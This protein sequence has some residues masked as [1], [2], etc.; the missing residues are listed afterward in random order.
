MYRYIFKSLVCCPWCSCGLPGDGLWF[1]GSYC[2]DES[3]KTRVVICQENVCFFSF[4]HFAGGRLVECHESRA[5]SSW[6]KDLP[7]KLCL[8][9][10]ACSGLETK[11]EYE[12]LVQCHESRVRSWRFGDIAF[13]SC[14]SASA[15]SSQ[16]VKWEEAGVKSFKI[17]SDCKVSNSCHLM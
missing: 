8:T 4:P 16:E 9:A 2:A 12:R 5:R 14:L 3:A 13:K 10:F 15:T 17:F 7:S 1:S 11:S 6:M